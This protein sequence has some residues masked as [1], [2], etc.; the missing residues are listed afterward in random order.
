VGDETEII[1]KSSFNNEQ[2]DDG[3][4][5]PN[6]PSGFPE[7]ENDKYPRYSLRNPRA[8]ISTCRGD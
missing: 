2:K 7:K 1:L 6:I 8:S 4:H 5:T 3:D